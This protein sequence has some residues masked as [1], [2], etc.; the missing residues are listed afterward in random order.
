ML[1][2][3]LLGL[4]TA[5]SL[6]NL[7][8]AFLGV[9]IGNLIGVIPGVGAMA[10]V[11]MLLPI[12]YGIEPAAALM[13]LAGLYYGTSYGGAITTILLNLPG[14]A[15]HAVVCID[16]HPLAKSGRAGP[17][18][19][20]AMLASFIGSTVGII[21][22]AGFGPALVN[23]AFKFG[24][25]EY[26]SLMLLGLL[27][28]STLSTGSALKAISM[29]VIGVIAGVVGTD[30]NSGVARFTFGVPELQDGLVMVAVAMGLFGVADVLRTAAAPSSA[31][32]TSNSKIG[33]RS[34]KFKP[35][36]FK[37][38]TTS[39]L[40][41]SS[42]GSFFG[43]LPGTGGALASFISYA[44]EKKVNKNRGNFGKGAME[45]VAAPEAANSAAAQTSFIPTL[46]LGIPGDAVMALILGA[47]MI[48]NIQPGPQ[49]MVNHPDIFWGLI[50]SFW[51][52]NLILLLL[53]VPL[54]SIWVKLL[55]VPYKFVFPSVLLFICIG[56][57]S[58]NNNIY[59]VF[60]VLA[61]GMFG[62]LA[63]KL[64][65]ELTPMLLGLVL[66]PMLEENFRR[67]ML[68]AQ[69][70]ITVF[71]TRPISAICIGIAFAL[72]FFSFYKNLFVR[73]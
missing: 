43:F 34:L 47:M 15:S 24:P 53:N 44:V 28:A 62:Y 57:F 30:I 64:G 13:M 17:A 16:G 48:H 32:M 31:S 7:M 54:I 23:V 26:F 9:F 14:T 68:L 36:E 21:L 73:R 3:I 25:S 33:F 71:V 4:S 37:N 46:S 70:D 51:I 29:V 63:I 2:N 67:A 20:M 19:L 50:A 65:F 59:D 72:I 22:M 27:A 1:D 66:G 6:N 35:K 56:A 69:G 11:A 41:G 60:V 49:L 58:A 12:T 8:F 40:R 61:V 39:I 45:G 5:L 10:A 18:L 52:G 38:S 42:V 55:T